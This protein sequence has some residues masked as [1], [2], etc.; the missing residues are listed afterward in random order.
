M[1]ETNRGGRPPAYTMLPGP[2]GGGGGG[3]SL[4][5]RNQSFDG[6]AGPSPRPLTIVKGPDEVLHAIL[7]QFSTTQVNGK[8]QLPQAPRS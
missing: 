2:C 3:G 1:M 6:G 8:Q 7:T 4:L 5:A